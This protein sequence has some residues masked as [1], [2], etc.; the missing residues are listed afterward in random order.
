MFLRNAFLSGLW[1]S[2]VLVE[3]FL[4]VVQV[5]EVLTVF[6]VF[7]QNRVQQRCTFLRNAFLSG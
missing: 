3:T 6:L 7:P 2:L 5:V 1:S 4:L